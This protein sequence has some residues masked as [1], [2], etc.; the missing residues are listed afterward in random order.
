M[1][2]VDVQISR[3]TKP[4]S[5]KGFGLS[6]LLATSKAID[7]KEYTG[8]E[9]VAEDFEETTNEYKLLSRMFGQNPRPAE[10]AV[11]GV[12]YDSA[13]AEPTALISSLNEL[14]KTHNDFYY[15]VSPEQGDEEITALAEWTNTKDKIYGA[16]T[17]NVELAEKLRGLYDNAFLVVHDQPNTYVAEGLIG[18]CA[19]KKIGAYTWTFKNVQGVPAVKYDNTMI[20]RIHAANAS[21]YINEAG[22]LLNS[23]GVATSGEFIDVIQ[24]THYLKARMAESVFRLLALRDKVPGTDTGIGLAVAE[25]ES[26]LASTVENTTTGEGIIARDDAGNPMYTITFPRRKDIPKNT[27]AQRILPDIQWTATISGAFEKVQIRGVL[28]V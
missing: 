1:R 21:T 22:L 8:I 7:Y 12:A 25:V 26:V 16:T 11:F 19:P 9:S 27:L 2:Y 17:S 5:E 24:A 18:V 4:I 14:I 13:T 15:V 3:E 6:L 28:T 10:I 20:N 23:K